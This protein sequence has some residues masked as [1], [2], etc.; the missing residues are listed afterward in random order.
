MLQLLLFASSLFGCWV[1]CAT[2]ASAVASP[3][4]SLIEP[5]SLAVEKPLSNVRA[6]RGSPLVLT[7]AFFGSP[8]PS[9]AWYHRGRK[10]DSHSSSPFSAILANRQLSQT[11]VE[12]ELRIPCLDESTIGEYFCEAVSECSPPVVTHSL[13]TIAANTDAV[14]CPSPS[15]P[16]PPII[17]AFTMSR[18]ELPEAVSELVCRARG[19]PTPRVRWYRIGDDDEMTLTPVEQSDHNLLLPNGDLLVIGDGT[20]ISES[21]RCVAENPYGT[22]HKDTAIIYMSP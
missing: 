17:A 19:S 4:A 9:I 7:C 21:Y 22:A 12:S 14:E 10:I 6:A 16:T 3:C 11:I 5:S 20:T 2:A 13:V 8:Q 18:I 1:Q 15:T